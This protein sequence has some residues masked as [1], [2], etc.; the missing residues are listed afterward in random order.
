MTGRKTINCQGDVKVNVCNIKKDD[1]LIL[2]IPAEYQS[3]DEYE[4]MGSEAK[5]LSKFL[6]KD[7]GFKVPVIVLAGDVSF[8]TINKKELLDIIND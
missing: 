1:I 7:L 8:K 6:E 5:K 4:H 2:T 3:M